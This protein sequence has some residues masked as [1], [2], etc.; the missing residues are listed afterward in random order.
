MPA[1]V[2]DLTVIVTPRE[3]FSGIDRCLDALAAAAGG[4]FAIVSVDSGAPPEVR[5]AMERAGEVVEPAIPFDAVDGL[6][7]ALAKVHSRW[8]VL[9]DGDGLP[10]ADAIARMAARIAAGGFDLVLPTIRPVGESGPATEALRAAG[11]RCLVA[12]TATVQRLMPPGAGIGD[13]QCRLLLAASVRGARIRMALERGAVVHELEGRATDLGP[14]DR[15][16]G[17]R[18]W[19]PAAI[20]R[21]LAAVATATGSPGDPRGLAELRVIARRRLAALAPAGAPPAPEGLLRTYPVAGAA[22]QAPA[23]VAVVVPT[24]MRPPLLRAIRSVYAQS[25]P[26]TIQILIG[27]D[28]L[29]GGLSADALDGLLQARPANVG[30]LVLAPGYSTAMR[31]GGIHPGR[32]GGALR[33]ILSFLA[34]APLVAYLDDDSWYLRDHL[35]QLAA[36]I[37]GFDWAFSMRWFADEEDGTLIC[38]DRWES[39]GPNKGMYARISGGLVDTNCFMVDKR[40]VAEALAAWTTGTTDD[41][42]GQD[43]SFMLALAQRHSVGWTGR[44]SVA[45]T[46]RRGS[47]LWRIARDP[48]CHDRLAWAAWRRWTYAESFLRWP[49]LYRLATEHAREKI[50]AGVSRDRPP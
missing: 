26:G 9:L 43:R 10:A 3:R 31:N 22:A 28:R 33:T 15:A 23:D 37:E 41:G 1:A 29:D 47:R 50:E 11:C 45:Y 8:T 35:G 38:R 20:E 42:A 7:R 4:P 14:E 27:A 19:D 6:R 39:V 16:L 24:V 21:A 25:F 40:R 32:G 48:G 17:R 44:H 49:D 36:A 13:L 46:V 34:N 5:R 30:A 2:P 18:Y 12:E